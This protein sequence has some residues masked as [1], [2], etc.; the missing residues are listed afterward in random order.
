[1]PS[2]CRISKGIRRTPDG[3][4]AGWFHGCG[5]CGSSATEPTPLDAPAAVEDDLHRFRK[6]AV[7][8]DE[9]SLGER[10]RRVVL[11]H[12]HGGLEH[13]WTAVELAGHEMDG[14]ATHSNAVR[15]RLRLRVDARESRKQ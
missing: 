1:M 14:C 6:D 7:L 15:E 10:R 9:N 8:L 4:P 12:R 2:C 3:S 13:D 11:E 5:S